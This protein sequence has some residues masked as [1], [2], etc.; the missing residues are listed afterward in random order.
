MKLSVAYHKCHKNLKFLMLNRMFIIFSITILFQF[1]LFSNTF[2]QIEH[3][4]EKVLQELLEGENKYNFLTNERGED[5]T[6]NFGDLDK[7]ETAENNIL[8]KS[9]TTIKLQGTQL[10]EFSIILVEGNLEITHS[11]DSLLKVQ[12]IIISP[13]GKLTIG[14]EENPIEKDKRAKIVFTKQKEGEIGIFVFGELLIHGYK[15]EPT[16]VELNSD[17]RIGD[18]RLV[19]KEIL[20][21]WESGNKVIITSPGENKCN[22]YAEILRVDK[23]FVTLK[24]QLECLHRGS[25]VGD[26][27]IIGSHVAS[28]NRNVKFISDDTKERG[29]IN[30]FYGSTGY[31]K[32]AELEKLGP[33]DVLGRYPI[34]FHH[35]K[36]TSRGIEVEGNSI[37]NSNNRWITIHDSNGV[38]VKNNVGYR[39]IGHGYFLEDGNEF[40]NIF[41]NNI[42]II[43]TPGALIPSDGGSAVFWAMN[44]FNIYRGNIAVDAQY[45]SYRFDIIDMEVNASQ[46]IPV[47][48]VNLRSL[49]FKEFDG[50]VAYNYGPGGLS[51]VRKTIPDE[52]I[53]S[54]EMIVSNF[55]TI[56]SFR[57]P[58]GGI[59]IKLAANDITILNSSII[60]NRL[61]IYLAGSQNKV[62]DTEIKVWP[63][64]S[65]EQLQTGIYI[66]GRNNLIKNTDIA[67]YVSRS[68]DVVSDI[69]LSNEDRHGWILSAKIINST[70]SSPLPI[71]FGNPINDE[72]FLE[73][74]GYDAPHGRTKNLPENFILKKI[75]T[76]VVEE[77][78]EYNNLEF[79][80]M[81]KIIEKTSSDFE[82]FSSMQVEDSIN[83][84]KKNELLK[85]FK[86]NAFAWKNNAQNNHDFLNEI[87]TLM[88]FRIIQLPN[89]EVEFFEEYTFI[90]PNWFKKVVGYWIEDDISDIEFI[91][92]IKFILESQLNEQINSYN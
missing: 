78:G 2:A 54:S 83:E 51:I 30:Y 37:L 77:R 42:G 31:I 74:Y 36:D 58:A 80:A 45:W 46:T 13:N 35:M 16:F 32:Y 53:D 22:E 40:D 75:G 26:A 86:N 38:I 72:S 73:V 7:L 67:G 56:N 6:S 71:F 89:L 79:M 44:P 25:N 62:I 68:N 15:I 43:T 14:T 39:S 41:E 9:G 57:S 4:H 33:R 20:N 5:F 21:G 61:G 66:I 18:K 59:G 12:K 48:K 91:N 27:K 19:V 10:A 47:D 92:G 63:I 82:D 81:I 49:P 28:L 52:R 84:K 85:S 60:N 17:A 8:I 76:D 87:K 50:N 3:D 34:H 88:E 11:E 55:Q 70:L 69:S 1:F 23:I 90:I 29:S 64:K 65:S 24:N